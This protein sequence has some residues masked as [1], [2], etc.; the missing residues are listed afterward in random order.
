MSTKPG[1]LL[2][3]V[4]NQWRGDDGVGPWIVRAL[5]DG[6]APD[7]ATLCG[8]NDGLALLDAWQGVAQVYAFDALSGAAA[9]GVAVRIDALCEALPNQAKVSSHAFGLAEAITLGHALGRLPQQLTVI[10]IEGR[11]FDHGQTLS[12]EVEAAARRVVA[13]LRIELAERRGA[14]THA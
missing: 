11:C 8:V 1:L 4:G 9:P 13:G 7:V 14:Q 10:G 2:V 12:P 6:L 5:R 3:G